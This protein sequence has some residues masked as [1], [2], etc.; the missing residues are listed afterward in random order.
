MKIIQENPEITQRELARQLGVSIG[1]TNYCIRMLCEK[2]WV[3]ATNFKNSRNKIAYA[4]LLTPWGVEQKAKMTIRF[5]KRK[6]KEYEMLK[7]EI[8]ELRRDA[9]ST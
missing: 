8:A 6:I 3:K 5:L 9:Q 2:G 1:K 4:Y 7:A